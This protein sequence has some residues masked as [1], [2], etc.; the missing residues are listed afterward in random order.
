MGGELIELEKNAG[1]Q[2]VL[3]LL[4]D[5]TKKVRDIQE[6]YAF[7]NKDIMSPRL[8]DNPRLSSE[9]TSYLS[10]IEAEIG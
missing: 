7:S 1:Y 4:Q 3:T 8:V 6:K 2:A 9:G 5:Y 10:R